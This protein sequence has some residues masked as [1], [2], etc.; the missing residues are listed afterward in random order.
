M[1]DLRQWVTTNPGVAVRNLATHHGSLSY[2][3]TGVPAQVRF[4]IASGVRVPAGGIVVMS[5]FARTPSRVIVNNQIARFE[6]G[7]VTVRG[8]PAEIIFQYQ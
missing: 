5:P 6:N 7:S 1:W 3:V 2:T 4:E 8:L